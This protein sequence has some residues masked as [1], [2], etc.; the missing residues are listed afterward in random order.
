MSLPAST[1][2]PWAAQPQPNAEQT[3][4]A[5][6]AHPLYIC[7]KLWNSSTLWS[8]K[9]TRKTRG[10]RRRMLKSNE[11]RVGTRPDLICYLRGLI[12]MDSQGFNCFPAIQE[13]GSPIFINSSIVFDWSLLFSKHISNGKLRFN[14]RTSN[15]SCQFLVNFESFVF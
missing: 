6:R 9:W 1:P 11:Q 3:R 12:L 4:T 14:W 2:Q 5:H 13:R 8:G 7:T 15:S 10:W